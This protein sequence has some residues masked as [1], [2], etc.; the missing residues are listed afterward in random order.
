MS[1]YSTP[2]FWVQ[3]QHVSDFKSSFFDSPQLPFPR[4]PSLSSVKYKVN[5]YLHI[6]SNFFFWDNC[7]VQCSCK[8]QCGKS[9]C[10]LHPV[11][12]NGTILQNDSTIS[13]P[14]NWQGYNSLI[15]FKFPQFYLHSC[16]CVCSLSSFS[17]SDLINYCISSIWVFYLNYRITI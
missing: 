11:S 13:Q 17:S 12:L 15:L 10:I 9:P 1:V 16:V 5:I 14:G 4:E 7:R 6:L 2:G 8:K 3:T